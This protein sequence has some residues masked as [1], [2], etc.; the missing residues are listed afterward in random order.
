MVNEVP[1][2]LVE[3]LEQS[4]SKHIRRWLGLPPSFSS[5]GLY[6]KSTKLQMPLN[7]LEEEFKVAKARL[8]L[9]LRDSADEKISRAGIE[10][11]TGRKWSVNKAVEQAESSLQH[12]VIVGATNQGREGLGM[13]KQP[14]WLKADSQERRS[15]VQEEIR[16]SE[17][18]K[19]SAR[20]VQM[21]QQGRWN[22]W[23]LPERKLSWQELWQYEPL[24][25]SFLLRSVH[26]LLP[27]P[28]NLV[29]WKF[30]EENF[31]PLCGQN[32][33]LGHILTA[34]PTALSQGRYTWRHD[35]VPK[36][37]A[38]TLEKERKNE[39]HPN[40]TG[41]KYINF[42]NEGQMAKGN[43]DTSL[44]QQARHWELQVDL[45]QKL[46]F[47]KMLSRQD[48]VQTSSSRQR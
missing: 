5:I 36:V 8:F 30:S 38:D 29:R 16:R 37:L 31:C 13:R 6:G 22:L 14:R 23:N 9:T 33:T 45:K 35:Q 15:M 44:L 28:T 42:V 27:T 24:Q 10:V 1:V 21:G 18:T 26:D 43:K 3:K 48:Y 11:R 12:Q 20:S 19:R 25:L 40:T 17:D 46:V 32:G 4:V 34:C 2:S 47:R 41:P 7:S 39:R